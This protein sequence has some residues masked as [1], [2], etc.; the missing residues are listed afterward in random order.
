M[1]T[2]TTERLEKV[3]FVPITV[4]FQGI[5][6]LAIAQN[7]RDNTTPHRFAESVITL[8]RICNALSY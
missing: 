6:D 5:S 4:G 7:Q 2:W 8:G 1:P 3:G